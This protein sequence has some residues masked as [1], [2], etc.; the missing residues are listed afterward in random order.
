MRLRVLDL[1][2]VALEGRGAFTSTAGMKVRSG[3]GLEKIVAEEQEDAA[4]FERDHAKIENAKAHPW[5]YALYVLLLGSV[6]SRSTYSA[7]RHGCAFAFSILAWSRSKDAA[8]SCSSATIF[9][10]PFP[11]LT[12][13]PAVEVKAPRGISVL[14]STNWCAGTS[15]ARRTAVEPESW[16][17][18]RT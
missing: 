13:I 9:S 5:R 10:R 16:T 18:P 17:S 7:Y 8:S 12:F 1:G 6:P 15:S 2:V 3:N 11:D 4:S 14:S